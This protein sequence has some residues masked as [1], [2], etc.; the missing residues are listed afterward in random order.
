VGVAAAG[1]STAAGASAAGTGPFSTVTS[2][3]RAISKEPGERIADREGAILRQFCIYG[4][5]TARI[6]QAQILEMIAG[7]AGG[8]RPQFG[9]SD[10]KALVDVELGGDEIHI[11]R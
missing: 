9:G 3:W 7:V 10:V 6:V 5:I 11:L 4:S 8:R 2:T 1:A